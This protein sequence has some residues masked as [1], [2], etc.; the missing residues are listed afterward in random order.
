[1]NIKLNLKSSSIEEICCDELLAVKDNIKVF[2]AGTDGFS[3]KIPTSKHF[4][5]LLSL[6]TGDSILLNCCPSCGKEL[7]CEMSYKEIDDHLLDT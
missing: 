3:T 4:F 2:T 1:M 6:E 5:F 7:R